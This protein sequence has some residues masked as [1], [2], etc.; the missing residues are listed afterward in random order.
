MDKANLPKH[1]NT[2]CVNQPPQSVGSPANHLSLEEVHGTV[3]VPDRKAGFWA[4]WRAFV[5]P[6][7]LVSVDLFKE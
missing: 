7:I 5:G 2:G 3:P 1:A 4:Q 6:A